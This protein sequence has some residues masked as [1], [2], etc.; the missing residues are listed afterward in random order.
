VIFPFA[1]IEVNVHLSIFSFPPNAYVVHVLP[2]F[3]ALS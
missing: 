1:Y 2:L 3:V